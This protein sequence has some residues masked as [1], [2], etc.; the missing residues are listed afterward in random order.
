[1]KLCKSE[2]VK[3]E[4]QQSF[5]V[6]VESM[7]IAKNPDEGHPHGLESRRPTRNFVSFLRP[8]MCVPVRHPTLPHEALLDLE[9]EMGYR[10]QEVRRGYMKV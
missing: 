6:V 1:M 3:E 10:L 4:W 7:K 9:Y 5:V 2:Q 8:I